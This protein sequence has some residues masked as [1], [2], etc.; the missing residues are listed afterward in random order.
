MDGGED[1][2]SQERIHLPVRAGGGRGAGGVVLRRPAGARCV[3]V[4]APA[5]LLFFHLL[6]PARRRRDRER[7]DHVLRIHGG[8]L[9]RRRA[10]P[11][12][13]GSHSPS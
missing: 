12:D 4:L 1:P 9:R 7:A 6:P 3:A 10:G 11:Q 13:R 2:P 8:P 5:M